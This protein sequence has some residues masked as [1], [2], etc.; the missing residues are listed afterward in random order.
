MSNQYWIGVISRSH[1][2]IGVKG[3]FMQ[4]NHGKRAPLARLKAGDGVVFYSPRESYPDGAPLQA[5]TAIGRIRT[6]EVYQAEMAPDFKPFRLDVE[7][8][9][10]DEAPIRP[11][12]EHLS[13]IKDKTHW[14]A[15]FRY[16]NLKVPAEDFAR[17]ARAM[18][19][20]VAA[21]FTDLKEV[22]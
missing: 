7:W 2:Q 5:F 4:L 14:G 20:D 11:M 10:A 12:I 19:I 1:V 8:L 22:A 15:A 21:S 17:I 18:Q 16:G 3:G 9:K 6:G 13:F